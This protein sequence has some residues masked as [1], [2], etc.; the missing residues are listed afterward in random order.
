M[1]NDMLNKKSGLTLAELI[2]AVVLLSLVG[3]A[4]TGIDV[5]SRRLLSA[6]DRETVTYLDATVA[7]DHMV[8][9]ISLATGDEGSFSNGGISVVG[10]RIDIRTDYNVSGNC[11]N[12]PDN[13][14]DD[15]WRRY[16]LVGNEI[17]YWPNRN[18]PGTYEVIS[19]R[20][21]TAALDLD[22]EESGGE[23]FVTIEIEASYFPTRP[24]G[25]NH[26]DNPLVKLEANV[27]P[28]AHTTDI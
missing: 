24:V 5:A 9:W 13:Y 25:A 6:V 10:F 23:F 18:V 8:K 16:E 7:M 2:M 20:V 17:R 12:T 3:L 26:P 1:M 27:S 22:F 4:V 28:R 21:R 15:T 19:T 11:L 14:G